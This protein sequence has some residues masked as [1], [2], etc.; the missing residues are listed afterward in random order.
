MARRLPLLAY[1]LG[2]VAALAGLGAS[3]SIG[4][5]SQL[6]AA[7]E[8]WL[9]A[10]RPVSIAPA[11]S[12]LPLPAPQIGAVGLVEPS[13]Q[14]ISIGTDI[15]GTVSKVFAVPG[16]KVSKGQPLFVLDTRMTEAVVAQRLR[17]LAAAE[18]RLTL[19]RSRVPGL[20]AEVQAAM[21]AVEAARADKDDATDVV[22]IASG[23]NSGDTI[24]AR[25]ITRRRNALRTAEAKYAEAAARLALAQANLA[26]YDEAK[27]GANITIELAAIE[28]ARA[29]LKLAQTDLELR[30]VSAPI[31]GEVLRV[32]IN[33]GEFALAGAVTQPLIVMGRTDPMH[34]RIDIDEADIS[35]YRPGARALASL[36][37]DAVR[38][39][40]LSFVR[41]EPLVVP[42]RALSG[43]TTER[44]DTRVMQLIY[45]ILEDGMAILPG[46]Q[47]D[48]LI[49][50]DDSG[51]QAAQSSNRTERTASH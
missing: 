14:E 10:P 39:L 3:V 22:R 36:R 8:P 23:L 11:P 49:E 7:I 17:D 29:S 24:S 32:N 31:D 35:R 9:A 16:V 27:G 15:S 41:V 46:Q 2:T 33:P 1:G 51:S 38:K 50:A 28:Q 21:T 44:V 4:N 6:R 47:V 19:A 13:S 34:V 42:K 26:L 5:Q 48:V 18:A 37:G 12:P 20:E 40:Q 25:E 45:A 30:T 43:L